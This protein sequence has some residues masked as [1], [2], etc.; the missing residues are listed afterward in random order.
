VTPM[1]EMEP[2]LVD[3]CIQLNGMNETIDKETFLN[4]ANDL[5]KD[6]STEM[7]VI[8]F[9][10]RICGYNP[11]VFNENDNAKLGRKYFNNF[12]LRHRDKI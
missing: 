5:I 1:V 3:L 10:K 6:T 11:T 7:R 4:L 2:L 8:D 12:M 9:M